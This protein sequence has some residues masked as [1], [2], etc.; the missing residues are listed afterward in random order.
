VVSTEQPQLR[1]V[2]T[3]MDQLDAMV[4]CG[5]AEALAKLLLTLQRDPDRVRAQGRASRR[6][7]ETRYNWARSVGDILCELESLV[8]GGQ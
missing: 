3:E 8:A 7:V 6:L 5:D 2:F 1:D 4:S